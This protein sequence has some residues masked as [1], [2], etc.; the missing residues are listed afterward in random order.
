MG[1]RDDLLAIPDALLRQ[2]HIGEAALV[3]MDFGTGAK[4]W[5]TGFGDLDHAGYIWQGTGDLITIGDI[6]AAKDMEAEA[7]RFGMTATAEML[8]LVQAAETAVRGR[9][10][11]VFSQMFS[12][13]PTDGT[14][15]WQPLG[16]PMALFTGTMEQMTYMA[17]RATG[18]QITL[19]CESWF[20]RRNAPPRGQWSD[21]D[22]RGI[23]PGDRGLERV[24]LYEDYTVR[25]V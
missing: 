19:T 21:L 7:L 8:A 25:W 22:Q 4:R 1:A 9:A 17:S 11:Q 3:F 24:P 16:P 18:R 2:G 23:Y 20:V 14:E 10:V 5:W 13:S 12:V 15:P 6:A